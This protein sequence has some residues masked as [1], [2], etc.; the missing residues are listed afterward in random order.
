MAVVLILIFG[1]ITRGVLSIQSNTSTDERVASEDIAFDIVAETPRTAS[2]KWPEAEDRGRCHKLGRSVGDRPE[3][4]DS[5]RRTGRLRRPR[6]FKCG[7]LTQRNICIILRQPKGLSPARPAE[8]KMSPSYSFVW[9]HRGMEQ[10]PNKYLSSKT[11]S[12]KLSSRIRSPRSAGDSI[13]IT[14]PSTSTTISSISNAWQTFRIPTC[15]LSLTI[16]AATCSTCVIRKRARRMPTS[17]TLPT[18]STSILQNHPKQGRSR[19]PYCGQ[20]KCPGHGQGL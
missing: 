3:D 14:L 2:P 8:I 5:D 13:P 1:L 19:L 20:S 6:H 12:A 16:R 10:N 15:L 9:P 17:S 4:L 7:A 18:G 11:K